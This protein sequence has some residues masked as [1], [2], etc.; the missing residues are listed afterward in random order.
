[1]NKATTE[2]ILYKT[3]PQVFAGYVRDIAGIQKQII[4]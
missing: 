4:Q 3:P 1:M 2:F